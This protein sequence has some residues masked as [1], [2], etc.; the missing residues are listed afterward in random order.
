[1]QGKY[2]GAIDLGTTG[3]RCVIFDRHGVPS[4]LLTT[5]FRSPSR[6]RDGSSKIRRRCSKRRWL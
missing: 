6:S 3:V 1:M 5:N 2:I 4:P